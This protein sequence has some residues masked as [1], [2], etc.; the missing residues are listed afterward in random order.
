MVWLFLV[1]LA[2]LL[3]IL[4][5][6]H[7]TN[8]WAKGTIFKNPYR[9]FVTRSGDID[10]EQVY[11]MHV[12][13]GRF[14]DFMAYYAKFTF[15]IVQNTFFGGRPAHGDTPETIVADIHR[16]RFDARW[17]Y[18][19]SGD[20]FSVLFPRNLGV[21]YNQLLNPNTALS[22]EDWQGRQQIYLQS[23]LFAID[24]LS[25]S[26][27]PRTTIMPIGARH[28][29]LNQVHPGGTGSDQVYGLFYALT[30]LRGQ[31]VSDNGRYRQTTKTAAQRVIAERRH[32]LQF[33][34][35][36]YM[37]AVYEPGTALVRHM[38]LSSA[39]DGVIRASSF[40]DNL[41]MYE[42]I[43][44]AEG[45]GLR[46]NIGVSV[47]VTERKLK[48]LYWNESQGYYNNDVKSPHFSADWLIGYVTGFFDL[49][50]KRDLQRTIRTIEYIE[51]T[52]LVRPLPI[53]YQ[54]ESRVHAPRMV[55]WFVPMYGSSAIWSYWG[56]QYIT[57]LLQVYRETANKE[58]LKKARAYIR[59]YRKNMVRDRG[60]P[61][62]FDEQGN[63]LRS[64]FYKSIRVTGWVV[65]FEYAEYL[66]RQYSKKK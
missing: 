42:T 59:Q 64:T 51:S 14:A 9:S 26:S 34:Y 31:T 11:Q 17:P 3:V 40:Y 16:Q 28:V 23:V 22:Q 6:F 56:A 43:R 45:L 39:R 41:I 52:D 62:T 48:E 18:L 33:I 58:Y 7:L 10:Y 60:F 1:L 61:E 5:W 38:H 2:L 35:D 66:L 13:T 20:Q 32:E 37:N 49:K 50:N 57:L 19:I 30:Q 12:F 24:G 27:D 53:K 47:K 25:A 36:S 63:F 4:E 46:D 15:L 8:P 29:I 44:L 55:Q 65:Q 54:V 21:F